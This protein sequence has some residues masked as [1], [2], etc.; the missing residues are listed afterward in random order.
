[1]QM[2]HA[3]KTWLMPVDIAPSLTQEHVGLHANFCHL[4]DTKAVSSATAS[5][6]VYEAAP[7]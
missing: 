6:S 4:Q 5:C 7:V 3:V 1:M 2:H